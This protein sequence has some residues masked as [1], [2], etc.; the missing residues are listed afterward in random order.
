MFVIRQKL[1]EWFLELQEQ[2]ACM[3]VLIL[4]NWILKNRDVQAEHLSFGTSSSVP[5][6]LMIR[7]D[8][9]ALQPDITISTPGKSAPIAD[10]EI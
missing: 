3:R 5:Y 7:V 8:F 9:D 2:L 6:V 1:I 4:I 10:M